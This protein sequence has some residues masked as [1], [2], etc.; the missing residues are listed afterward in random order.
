M[1]LSFLTQPLLDMPRVAKR[2]LALAVDVA[3]CVGTVWL[4]YCLRLESLV[5]LE[6]VQLW[7][8]WGLVFLA[9]PL[10]VR[11]GLYRAIFRYSGWNAMQGVGMAIGLYGLFYATIFAVVGVAGVPRSVGVVQPLLLFVAVG[12]SRWSAASAGGSMIRRR[13]M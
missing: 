13:A 2:S 4:A 5:R 6:G 12:G 3:L 9:L 1:P 11:L 8:V 7:A 10:F